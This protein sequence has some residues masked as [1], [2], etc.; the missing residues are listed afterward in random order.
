VENLL[1]EDYYVDSGEFP[2]FDPTISQ[3]SVIAATPEQVRRYSL[4]MEFSF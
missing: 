3:G 4:S 1:D 2:N